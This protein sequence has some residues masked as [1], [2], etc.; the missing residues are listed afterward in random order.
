MNAAEVVEGGVWLCGD[1]S[2]L[3]GSK[4]CVE[5]CDYEGGMGALGGGEIRLDAEMKIYGAGDKPEALRWAICG[6][7]SISV[8][9]RMPE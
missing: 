9:P 5:A 1:A 2:A 3:A 4:D 8:N 7:F 6:G